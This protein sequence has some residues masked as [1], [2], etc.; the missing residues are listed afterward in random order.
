MLNYQRLNL[1]LIIAVLVHLGSR[2]GSLERSENEKFC[3]NLFLIGWIDWHPDVQNCHWSV[4]EERGAT[5][6]GGFLK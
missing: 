3:H 1:G 2:I 6:L 5:R 4:D